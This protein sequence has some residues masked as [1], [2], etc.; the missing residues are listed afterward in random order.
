ML[1]WKIVG[2]SKVSVIYIYIYIYIFFRLS[3]IILEILLYTILHNTIGLNLSGVIALSYLGIKDMK[4][5][6]SAFKI[7]L[8]FLESS[9]TSMISCLTIPQHALKKSTLKPF[10]PSAFPFC[11]SLMTP[12]TS[13]SFT[14]L[15]RL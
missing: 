2:V 13:S 7:V 8:Y 6:L 11:I 12:L 4:E 15:F 1:K 9:T 5:V 3:K 14:G 10:R